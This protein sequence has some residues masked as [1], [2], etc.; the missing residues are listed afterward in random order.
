MEYRRIPKKIIICGPERRLEFGRPG[1]R[2]RNQYT[3]QEEEKTSPG[4]INK[5]AD[6]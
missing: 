5:Q 4:L 1:L 3:L 2:W 6:G